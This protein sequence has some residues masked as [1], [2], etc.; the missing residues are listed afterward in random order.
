MTKFTLDS[1]R[2]M[3]KLGGSYHETTQPPPAGT[4]IFLGTFQKRVIDGGYDMRGEKNDDTI[5]WL[6]SPDVTAMKY[7]GDPKTVETF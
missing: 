7:E 2:F 5:K 4:E 1:G 6:P 3:V